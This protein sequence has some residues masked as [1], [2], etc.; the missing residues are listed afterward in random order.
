[1]LNYF[2]FTLTFW[3]GCKLISEFK[4][5]VKDVLTRDT[6]KNAK[7]V[8]GNNGLN[9]H[10]KWTHILETREF[11]SLINGGELILTTGAG[12]QLDSPTELAYVN[13]LIERN[14]VGICIEIGIHVSNISSEIIQLADKHDFPII[15]FEEV[16]K[17][18]DI[19]QDLH[20]LIINQHHQMLN[21]LNLLSKKFNELSLSPNGILKILQELYN[22]F[23]KNALFITDDIK[24]YYYPPEIKHIEAELCSHYKNFK[25]INLQKK[26]LSLDK[27]KFT[28]LPVKGL[29]QVWGYLCL[30]VNDN[31]LDEFL[32][33]VLDRAAL[34]I[35]QIMLRNRTIKERKQNMEDK[36]VRSLLQGKEYESDNLQ[37]ILPSPAKNLY[38]RV[39][40]IETNFQEINLGEDDLEEIK[41]Q[42]SMMIRSLFKHQGFFPA[43]SVG[44]N[45]I[46]IISSFIAKEHLIKDTMKFSK[47]IKSI[48][49]LYEDSII[50]GSKCLFGVSKVYKDI[51]H[52]KRSYEEAKEVLHLQKLKVS[53]AYFYENIGIYR[54][55]L[56]LKNSGHLKS[57]TNDYIGPL[58]SYDKE[59]DSELL[60]TLEVYL[61]CRGAKKEA[62]DRLFIVRQT[63]YHRLEKIKQLLGENF[64][65]PVNRLALETAIKAHQ[66]LQDGS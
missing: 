60:T 9:R 38:Y 49:Q 2:E 43:I 23:Q 16:V 42:R 21:Q 44:K 66:L 27:E 41:L 29:G 25:S 56:L 18:V 48:I 15:L 58:L 50:D 11:E 61:E 37:A 53:Q 7:V 45:E 46:A 28:L 4:L 65:E 8:A 20:S 35:A 39:F 33:S 10:V 63:L 32:F 24:P 31:F 51:S 19:T 52:L 57:Y 40:L 30:Q 59:M 54:L 55:L 26:L 13:K 34:A 5:T 17:F 47:I 12:L 14:A 6:F 62:A 36:L 3:R 64:M 22:Y 1:M